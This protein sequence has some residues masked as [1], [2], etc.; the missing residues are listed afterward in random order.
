MSHVQIGEGIISGPG[1]PADVVRLRG[2]ATDG[3]PLQCGDRRKLY[4]RSSHRK[5]YARGDHSRL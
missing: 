5:L 1:Y 3:N 4:A 2:Q